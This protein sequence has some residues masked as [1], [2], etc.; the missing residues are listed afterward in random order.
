MEPT[1]AYSVRTSTRARYAHLTVSPRDGVVVVVPRRFD[2]SRIPELVASRAEWIRRAERRIA[3][4]R[5]S[6]AADDSA[7]PTSVALRAVGEEWCVEYA[8]T[9]HERVVARPRPGAVL[10][11]SGAID[12]EVAVADA[13]TRWLV[14]R[15]RADVVPWLLSLAAHHGAHVSGTSVRA[16]R[17]RWASCSSAGLVSLNRNVLFLPRELAEHVLLHEICHLRE[18]SHSPRF[19]RLLESADPATPTRR[20]ELYQAWK[21][22]PAWAQP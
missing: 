4:E 6:I 7:L 14:A 15:T 20:R 18:L 1:P 17:S 8:R 21:Y 2:R 3:S 13:L 19:W 12:D 22:V 11:M 16:Q 5:A 9:L 10:S